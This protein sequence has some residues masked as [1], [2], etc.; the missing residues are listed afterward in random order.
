MTLGWP[1]TNHLGETWWQ[2]WRTGIKRSC[3][4]LGLLRKGRTEASSVNQHVARNLKR[5]RDGLHCWTQKACRAH[6]VLRCVSWIL[7]PCGWSR[8]P[9]PSK[10]KP[11]FFFYS[12]CLPFTTV[13]SNACQHLLAI[14]SSQRS[15]KPNVNGWPNVSTMKDVRRRCYGNLKQSKQDMW[16]GWSVGRSVSDP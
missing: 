13:F 7:T 8:T 9:H 10:L 1:P 14:R 11:T 4:R 15:L 6:L 3:S 16:A 5:T 2:Y 12:S